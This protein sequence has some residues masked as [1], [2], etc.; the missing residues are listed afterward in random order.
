MA[1]PSRTRERFGQPED[2][3]DYIERRLLGLRNIDRTLPRYIFVEPTTAP[4]P[5]ARGG[6]RSFPGLSSKDHCG[7][8]YVGN[9]FFVGYTP[10]DMAPP[11]ASGSGTSVAGPHPSYIQ[12]AHPYIFQSQIEEL[13]LTLGVNTA[14]EDA[15]RIQGVQWIQDVR[16][17]LQL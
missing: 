12:V 17:A 8:R 10:G 9:N 3:D 2:E 5:P 4:S 6:F 15:S 11:I 1:D 7:G 16:R 13:Q 14:R